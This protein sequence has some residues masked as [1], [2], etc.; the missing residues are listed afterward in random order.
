[1][2]F[3]SDR[4]LAIAGLMVTVAGTAVALW[5]LRRTRRA[6]EAARRA[7]IAT[8]DV[9]RAGDLRRLIE[10]TTACRKRL[11]EAE[12]STRAV[13][14]VLGDWLDAYARIVPLLNASADVNEANKVAASQ[15]LERSKGD[16]LVVRGLVEGR[17][18]PKSLRL[19]HLDRSLAAYAEA[20]GRVLL[21][22]E[23]SQVNRHVG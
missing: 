6:A 1:M 19:T 17:T 8:K 22:L 13:R 3:T 5:Q 4:I 10:I 15:E 12:R 9:L 14:I 23:D 16:V 21:D 20:M 11:D 18:I 7:S 2:W